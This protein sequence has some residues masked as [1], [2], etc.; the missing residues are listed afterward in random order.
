MKN[1]GLGGKVA[2]VTGAGRGMG[3]AIAE[4]F[5]Q[6]GAKVIVAEVDTASGQEVEAAIRQAGGDARFVHCDVSNAASVDALMAATLETYGRLDCACNNAAID[7]EASLFADVSDEMADMLYGV[8]FRGVFLCMKRQIKQMLT[9]G[10]GTIV[11]ITSISAQRP[12]LTGSVYSGTKAGVVA[13][14]KGAAMTYGDKGVRIN[15]VAPG[16]IDTPML[17]ENVARVGLDSRALAKMLSV[18]GRLGT[19]EEI[20][21][22]VLWLSSDLSTFCFGHVLAVDGGYLSR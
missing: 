4:G 17:A 20:A 1:Y 22:A 3:R 16:G 9:Q 11:N 8:N 6:Q 13:M 14:T 19:P 2:L 21:E 5:A 10:G 12:H 15:M 18:N 7:K